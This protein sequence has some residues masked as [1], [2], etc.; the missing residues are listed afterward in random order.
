MRPGQPRWTE[1]VGRGEQHAIGLK[2]LR[3]LEPQPEAAAIADASRRHRIDDFQ[4]DVRPCLNRIEEALAHIFAEELAREE[5]V[6]EAFMQAGM[7]FALIE[8]AK[9]PVQKI[10]RLAGANR[11]IA[12][13]HIEK[14]QGMMRAIGDATP[15][16]S[17]RFN[18]DEAERPVDAG[19]AGDGSRRAG[20]STA[21]YADR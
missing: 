19:K 5:G 11:K 21:D 6:G 4:L 3:P 15:K 16:R 2:R 8:L 1:T 18:H 13:A 17:A 14:M 7:I 10:A 9:G 12:G 20:E